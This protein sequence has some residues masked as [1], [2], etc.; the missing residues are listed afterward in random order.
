[1]SYTAHS[2]SYPHRLLLFS[3]W[4]GGC[5]RWH[6]RLLS[7]RRSGRWS[8]PWQDIDEHEWD[9]TPEMDE[10]GWSMLHELPP[11]VRELQRLFAEEEAGI[12]RL[13]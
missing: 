8:E 2:S 10:W 1:M 9:H 13:F 4:C 5:S 6:F 3:A 12:R 7:Q 11:A